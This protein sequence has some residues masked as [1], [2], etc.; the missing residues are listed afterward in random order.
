MGWLLS[1][2]IC[3]FKT[4]IDTGRLDLTHDA[5]TAARAA[6]A[7]GAVVVLTLLAKVTVIQQLE[8]TNQFFRFSFLLYI[9]RGS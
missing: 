9:N 6:A 4:E 8:R 5:F 2:G 7:C 1:Q 3:F